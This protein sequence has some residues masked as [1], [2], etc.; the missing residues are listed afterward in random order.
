[1]MLLEDVLNRF[2]LKKLEARTSCQSKLGLYRIL[3]N[4]SR[5]FAG[6]LARKFPWDLRSRPARQTLANN[7][8]PFLYDSKSPPKKVDEWN[9]L[10][11]PGEL[12]VAC[13]LGKQSCKPPLS[14]G[15]NDSRAEEAPQFDIVNFPKRLSNMK[16][17]VH[18]S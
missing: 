12:P 14:P 3:F 7:P 6:V 13:P 5:S 2:V 1:M 10:A 15:V 11:W 4:P 8:K 17:S 18:R 9:Q 16:T